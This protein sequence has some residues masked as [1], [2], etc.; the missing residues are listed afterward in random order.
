MSK[1]SS[2]E[3]SDNDGI[4]DIFVPETPESRSDDEMSVDS[5]VSANNQGSRMELYVPDSDECS[6]SDTTSSMGY[7]GLDEDLHVSESACTCSTN[8]MPDWDEMTQSDAE[9]LHS[10]AASIFVPESTTRSSESSRSL[11]MRSS[12]EDDH[13]GFNGDTESTHVPGSPD[14]SSSVDM[15]DSNDGSCENSFPVHLNAP[16]VYV[17]EST[18]RSSVSPRTNNLER[19]VDTND[20]NTEGMRLS[21]EHLPLD[22]QQEKDDN[23]NDAACVAENHDSDVVAAG[24]DQLG[25]DYDDNILLPL[26]F[27][28]ENESTQTIRPALPLEAIAAT[29]R[30][31]DDHTFCS[32]VRYSYIDRN[33]L[34]IRNKLSLKL[35]MLAQQ[36]RCRPYRRNQGDCV[37]NRRVTPSHSARFGQRQEDSHNRAESHRL[38]KL[39]VRGRTVCLRPYF[40][41]KSS[42][43]L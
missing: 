13:V 35:E 18:T 42:R 29:K 19:A 30:R 17:S 1:P 40:S 41:T 25:D 16:S 14:R 15:A 10:N 31:D 26:T 8:E 12:H 27:L 20:N 32:I 36:H 21:I 6:E 43:A 34:C 22:Q 11:D 4:G 9:S 39:P 3:T 33:N 24:V 37:S 23:A 5:S 7:N 38:V 2:I 28:A